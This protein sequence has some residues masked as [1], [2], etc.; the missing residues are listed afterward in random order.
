MS[1]PPRITNHI[2][3]RGG[4][5]IWTGRVDGDGRPITGDRK[6]VDRWVW[7]EH[8]G[9]P[10]VNVTLDHWP[11]GERLCVRFEHL[12]VPERRFPVDVVLERLDAANNAEVAAEHLRLSSR[13]LWRMKGRLLTEWEADRLAC[14]LGWHPSWLWPGWFPD[15]DAAEVLFARLALQLRAADVAA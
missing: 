9:P 5:H 1:L 8:A 14:R 10:P 3:L 13:E 12:R 15:E 6:L 11:C 7:K 4:C 2:E